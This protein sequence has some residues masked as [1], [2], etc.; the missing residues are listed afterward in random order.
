MGVLAV[1]RLV[2]LEALLFAEYDEMEHRLEAGTG[3]EMF[4]EEPE[5]QRHELQEAVDELLQ[6]LPEALSPEVFEAVLVLSEPLIDAVEDLM[7]QDY[8]SFREIAHRHTS[9]R[10]LALNASRSVADFADGD[11]SAGAQASTAEELVHVGR[12]TSSAVVVSHDPEV[13]RRAEEVTV[14]SVEEFADSLDLE[15]AEVPPW[16]WEWALRHLG[17]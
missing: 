16:L 2:Q 9:P 12:G 8:R 14:K 3:L 13:A 6:L 17:F 15:L 11:R 1:G 10:E 5:R 4:A 7:R